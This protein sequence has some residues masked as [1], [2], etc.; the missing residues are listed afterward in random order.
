MFLINALFVE[1]HV[2]ISGSSS[3]FVMFAQVFFE[4]ERTFIL[5][6]NILC[7]NTTEGEDIIIE[8]STETKHV[9]LIFI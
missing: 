9:L 2:S 5:G 8:T 3:H 1:E 6:A 4:L 7:R